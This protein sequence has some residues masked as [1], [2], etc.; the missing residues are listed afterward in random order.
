MNPHE[1]PL[2]SSSDAGPD[3]PVS[4]SSEEEDP[5]G[6][7]GKQE[8][9]VE[10]SEEEETRGQLSLDQ[11]AEELPMKREF[12]TDMT[13]TKCGVKGLYRD[14]I[15]LE[16]TSEDLSLHGA[17]NKR[18]RKE[19]RER[20][21]DLYWY[22][23]SCGQNYEE[24]SSGDEHTASEG[25]S[26]EEEEKTKKPV[27]KKAKR[28]E[29]GK[30]KKKKAPVPLPVQP[31]APSLPYA[32]QGRRYFDDLV[33]MAAILV[34]SPLGP[35]RMMEQL[36]KQEKS[37]P[38]VLQR[39]VQSTLCMKQV[40]DKMVGLMGEMTTRLLKQG[41]GNDIL[42]YN[43]LVDIVTHVLGSA[44][45]VDHVEDVSEAGPQN[46]N[47]RCAI[48][49]AM[50]NKN[51]SR[52]YA[53]Y[54]TMRPTAEVSQEPEDKVRVVVVLE[55]WRILLEAFFVCASPQTWFRHAIQPLLTKLE[56]AHPG[57]SKSSLSS[58]LVA[59]REL[60]QP[61]LNEYRAHFKTIAAFLAA[62]LRFSLRNEVPLH[63]LYSF[64]SAT[65]PP[66]KLA[67][68]QTI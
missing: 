34:T 54:F 68:T 42:H 50:A 66:K 59:D 6:S 48:T 15:Q 11:L 2:G 55:K 44:D 60:T 37:L 18:Q 9:E 63:V 31:V 32:E 51:S 22:C 35:V 12:F 5:T 64:I 53:M 43:H 29:N 30:K 1:A 49:G 45:H 17:K 14:R 3:P 58:K 39:A 20:E 40:S 7:N 61:L 57:A 67:T 62:D 26:S 8:E 46:H 19:L 13:C 23:G 21:T 56:A 25:S 47:L 38:E 33:R 10:N 24:K 28:K 36:L 41:K 4:S 65:D 27:K 52:L 16:V